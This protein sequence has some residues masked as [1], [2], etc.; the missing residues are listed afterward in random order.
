MRRE[1]SEDLLVR[2]PSGI[3]PVA[4]ASAADNVPD[5]WRA[6]APHLKE[7]PGANVLVVGGLAQSVGI[8]AAGSAVACGASRV[9]YLDDDQVRRAAAAR[10]GAT[11][12][13]LNLAARRGAS[14]GEG[15]SPLALRGGPEQF[16]ITV[17]AAGN[18]EAQ[19]H[20]PA[21]RRITPG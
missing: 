15:G 6:V 12:E 4:V 8:Y 21:A 13:P 1:G 16:E 17:D 5:G 18:A 10:L 7:R 3:D 14:K 2:L 20:P 19:C 9:L 11:A